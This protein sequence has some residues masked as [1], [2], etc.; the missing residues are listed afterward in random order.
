MSQKTFRNRNTT[1]SDNIKMVR[2]QEML[3]QR[4][5]K[6]EVCCNR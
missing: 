3:G 4:N 5:N 1:E 2:D 6:T